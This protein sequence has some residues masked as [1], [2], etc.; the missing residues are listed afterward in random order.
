MDMRIHK[1]S[2]ATIIAYLVLYLL[3]GTIVTYIIAGVISKTSGYDFNALI[4]VM[5]SGSKADYNLYLKATFANTLANFIMYLIMFVALVI[6]NFKTLI[7]EFKKIKDHP[8]SFAIIA[9]CGFVALYGISYAINYLYDLYNI[10]VSTNQNAIISY[11]EDGSA[12]LTFI[13][14]V[15]LA[16]LVEELV[17]RY[18]IFDLCPK[19]ILAYIISI[20]IFAL[21]HML[22][23]SASIGEWLLLLIPYLFSGFML[24]LVYDQSQNIY[25]SISVHLLNNLL[26]YIMIIIG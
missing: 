12:V 8:I 13:A 17:Y 18:A 1:Q 19:R 23:T 2:I 11:I 5:A 3:G 22:S 26:S 14:V 4:E 24:A 7:A 10:G 6:I 15:I 16:P 9:I 25:A 21:P 20:A